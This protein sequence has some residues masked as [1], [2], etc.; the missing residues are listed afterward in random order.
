MTQVDTSIYQN[1]EQP[2]AQNPFDLVS[3]FTNIQ[4]GMAENQLLQQDLGAREGA[5]ASVQGSMKEDGTIDMNAFNQAV[6]RDPRTAFKAQELIRGAAETQQRQTEAAAAKFELDKKYSARMFDYTLPL[7]L[8][9]DPTVEDVYEVIANTQ[10]DPITAAHQ[11]Q[12]EIVD[13]LNKLPKND[14]GLLRK[15]AI[16]SLRNYAAKAGKM[17]ALQPKFEMMTNGAETFPVDTN[18]ITNPDYQDFIV[19]HKLSPAEKAQQRQSIGKD[20]MG[21][22]IPGTVTVGTLVDPYGNPR[23]APQGDTLPPSMGPTAAA[24]ADA[25]VP[26]AAPVSINDLRGP[27]GGANNPPGFVQS[28]LT[29]GE[30]AARTTAAQGSAEQSVE[31]QRNAANIPNQKALLGNLEAQLDK[32]GAGRLADWKYVAKT[33]TNAVNPFGDLL[34]LKTIASQEEFNKQAF[35]LAQEQFKSLGGTGT[36][37][38]Y[39]SAVSTSPNELLS[40]LGN[41]GI[42]HLLKGNAD[43]VAKMNEGWQELISQGASPADFGRYVAAFNKNFDPRV[44]QFQYLDAKERKEA[45]KGMSA[46][47]EKDFRR[48]FH[49]A[50]EYGWVP[51]KRKK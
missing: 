45:L 17:E 41:K 19:R 27:G 5:A 28:D 43:A 10:A 30:S 33:F 44:F 32:F 16:G 20:A 22:E 1:Q 14:S 35:Q 2:Q 49:Q 48:K 24:G 21:R 8:K 15:I 46:D 51:D 37:T 29:P 39:S 26:R 47:E 42:I 6:A 13:M 9:K 38:K 12:A 36:D 23:G 4:K 34:D 11:T 31:L 18:I 7:A 25:A 3:K 40:N 50:V